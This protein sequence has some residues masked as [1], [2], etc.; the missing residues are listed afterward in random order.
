MQN[1]IKSFTV[2]SLFV[3]NV[4]FA[5]YGT[6]DTTFDGDGKVSTTFKNYDSAVNFLALQPDGKLVVAGT[7]SSV[8]NS[9]FGLARYNADGS[10][11]NTF[12]EGG[13][14]VVEFA[15]FKIA[16]S[17]IVLQDGKIIA[18]GNLF[19][20]DEQAEHRG[21]R[22]RRRHESHI[23]IRPGA[24]QHIIN[25]IEVCGSGQRRNRPR[26]NAAGQSF[27]ETEWEYEERRCETEIP[28]QRQRGT[29]RSE[30]VSVPDMLQQ[31][32]KHQS[33]RA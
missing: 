27:A 5:Q 14:K 2:L 8:G 30:M 22:E 21:H 23:S 10:L 26:D 19:D 33:H 29:V 6:L 12:G 4:S 7:L 17:A 18:G 3:I 1:F 25:E 9:Q 32:N 11:D 15:G 16:L 13:K 20:E 28:D 31:E 24:L